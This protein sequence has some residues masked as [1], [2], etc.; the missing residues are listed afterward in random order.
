MLLTLEPIA[1]LI[2]VPELLVP[3]LVIEPTM[4]TAPVVTWSDCEPTLFSVTLPEPTMP[5]EAMADPLAVTPFPMIVRLLARVI[6]PLSVELL[7]LVAISLSVSVPLVPARTLDG[8]ADGEIANAERGDWVAVSGAVGIAEQHG[9]AVAQSPSDTSAHGASVDGHAAGEGVGKAQGQ[10]GSGA[11]LRHA[12]HVGSDGAA[13]CGGARARAG[14]GN[15]AG[16]IDGRTR[17]REGAAAAVGLD[18]QTIVAGDTAAEGGA[19]VGAGVA[20]GRAPLVPDARRIGLANVRPVVPTSSE[21]GLTSAELS[22]RVML[23]PPKALALVVP[24]TVPDWMTRPPVVVPKVLMP[25]KLK[26]PPAVVR[27]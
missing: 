4:L 3:T 18:D 13:Y 8:I 26:L 16:V 23:P 10:G 1:L 27:V 2:V 21:A 9:A 11:V 12:G 17:E 25:P 14:D 6:R 22:P 20:D 15:A 7:L 24:V 19:D 5:P